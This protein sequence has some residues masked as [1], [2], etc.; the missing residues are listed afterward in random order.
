M[1]HGYAAVMVCVNVPRLTE[2][3]SRPVSALDGATKPE[4]GEGAV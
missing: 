2:F 1:H 4:V 3:R